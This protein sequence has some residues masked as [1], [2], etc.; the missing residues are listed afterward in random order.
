MKIKGLCLAMLLIT[1]N[2]LLFGCS[3]QGNGNQTK[4]GK[5][6][7]LVVYS[8]RPEDKDMYEKAFA[9]FEKDHPNIHLK[10]QPY[11]STEYNTILS[12]AL[13]SGKGP[14][15]I[16]LRPYSGAT[17]IADSNYLTSLDDLKGLN[18]IKKE[19]L[20]AAK[21]S[22]GKVYGVPLSL[23]S[24]VIFYN[25]KIFQD[26]GISIPKTWEDFMAACKKLKQNNITPIAQA[27]KDAYLL[28][29]THSVISPSSYNGSS[30]VEKLANKQT[31]LKDPMF[32]ESVQRMKDLTPY[33]P[34]NFIALSDVDAQP[35]FLGGKAAMYING[36]YR[37]ESFKQTAPNL[38]I[39]IIPG[40]ATESGGS[41]IVSTWVDGSYAVVKKS[42][43]QKEAKQF[44]E[45]LASKS[46][47]KLFSDTVARQSAIDGITPK[48]SV[49]KAVAEA[50][51]KNTTPYLMLVKYGTGTP[52]TKTNFE[53]ALQGMYLGKL[54]V[55]QVVQEVEKSAE[56]NQK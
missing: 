9:L 15:I 45:F 12:N 19:Y 39:G 28:S 54:S 49:E 32:V 56:K 27:G 53:T 30:F 36:D 34:K 40:L 35:L 43:H 3:I 5:G 10:F 51:Q 42:P 13:V 17:S 33:F 26:N 4:D 37:L 18:N 23:D 8:W 44:M 6:T 22:D 31:N 41:P 16:Q 48:N 24:G 50:G 47:G 52:T 2:I 21:G 55:N 14:D 7:N 46:F 20:D 11:Q 38:S 29:L 1:V 25:K